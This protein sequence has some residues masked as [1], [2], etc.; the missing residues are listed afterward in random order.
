MS[1]IISGPGRHSP[2]L[3]VIA[4]HQ[5]PAQVSEIALCGLSHLQRVSFTFRIDDAFQFRTSSTLDIPDVHSSTFN[6]CV[7]LVDQW[8][9]PCKHLYLYTKFAVTAPAVEHALYKLNNR[10]L[11][12]DLEE[13]QLF[14]LDHVNYYINMHS[15]YTLMRFFSLK[16]S[17]PYL[18]RLN[19]GTTYVCTA[20][21]KIAFQ[22]L[23][24]V[25]NLK[26]LSLVFD[27]TKLH[28][29]TTEKPGGG[30]CNTNITTFDVGCSPIDEP[31]QVAVALSAILPWLTEINAEIPP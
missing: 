1:S 6:L 13:Y 2:P 17:W 27:A 5:A 14:T 31:L 4:L 30:V 21:P 25:L 22:G 23:V 3:K 10:V 15:A 20:R 19:I 11:C 9:V 18:E 26:T 16:S 24:T 28:P 8:V 29:L 12:D 7:E